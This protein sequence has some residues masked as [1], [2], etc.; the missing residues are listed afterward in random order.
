VFCDFFLIS[1][2]ILIISNT[3]YA[4]WIYQY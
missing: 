2:V 1:I 4:A 3:F